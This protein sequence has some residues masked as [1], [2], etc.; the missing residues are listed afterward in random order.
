MQ[1]GSCTVTGLG[2]KESSD[3]GQGSTI[4]LSEDTVFT[5]RCLDLIGVPVSAEVLVSIGS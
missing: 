4:A 1:Q 3:S 5:L 2:F